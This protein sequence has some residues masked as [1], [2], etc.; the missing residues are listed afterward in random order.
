[1]FAKNAKLMAKSDVYRKWVARRLMNDLPKFAK[2]KW[3]DF[4]PDD[5]LHYAGLTTYKPAKSGMGGLGVFLLGAAV[6]G[7]VALMM[8]PRPGSELRTTVKDKAM[9]YIN[10]QNIGMG[11]EKTASA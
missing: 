4:D 11:T 3:E 6:G 8:A 1:M 2:A 5:V 7:I 10:K 9:G